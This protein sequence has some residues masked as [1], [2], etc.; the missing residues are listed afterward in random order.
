MI[1]RFIGSVLSMIISP[2]I[3]AVMVGSIVWFVGRVFGAEWVYWTY[4][5]G[6]Y[7]GLFIFNLLANIFKHIN[8]ED[9]Y[10]GI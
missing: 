3:V 1:Y 6:W 9:N 5:R 4:I 10:R 8:N 2:F 7:V